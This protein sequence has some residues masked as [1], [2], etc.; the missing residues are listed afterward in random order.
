MAEPRLAEHLRRY[1]LFAKLPDTELTSLAERARTRAF[2]RGETLFRKDDPGTHLYV[3]LDGAVKTFERRI[4]SAPT[5]QNK[6]GFEA[7]GR[8]R[9]ACAAR[10]QDVEVVTYWLDRQHALMGEPSSKSPTARQPPAR[11]RAWLGLFGIP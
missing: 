10:R 5:Q 1:P 2:K 7:V 6:L 11:W 9:I 3:M 4:A 8:G